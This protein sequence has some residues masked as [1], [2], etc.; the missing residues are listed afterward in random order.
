[1]PNVIR[2]A[3]PGY[4]ALTDTDSDH[5]ALYGDE[6]WVL[7]K[8]KERGSETVSASSSTNIAHGLSYIPTVLV[9]AEAADGEV[10]TSGRWYRVTGKDSNSLV[11]I[12]VTTTNLILYNDS[13]T[14]SKEFKYYIFYDQQA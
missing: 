2:V 3:L 8:E 14:H 7:I 4:N 6:D 12:E 11:G 5:F 10:G 1:M 13:S 9:F